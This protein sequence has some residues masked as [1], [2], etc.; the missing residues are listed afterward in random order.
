MPLQPGMIQMPQDHPHENKDNVDQ[1]LDQHEDGNISF[2]LCSYRE[3]ELY[4]NA[5]EDKL[6]FALLISIA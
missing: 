2:Y 1:E 3:Q 6:T 4:L 5:T